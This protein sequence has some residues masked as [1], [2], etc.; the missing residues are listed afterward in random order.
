VS[1][2]G[3]VSARAPVLLRLAH[4]LTGDPPLAA[5][6]VTKVV[7]RRRVRRAL[8]VADD[9]VVVTALVRA[10]LRTGVLGSL[11]A[12]R[13]SALSARDRVATVLAFGVGWDAAGIAEAMRTTGRRVRGAVRR[14]L[15]IAPEQ[16]WRT[17][18]ADVRWDLAAG[19]DLDG[20]AA[21][22]ARDRRRHRLTW[23]IAAGSPLILVAGVA[24]AV[25]RVVTAPP[26]PPP[27]AQVRGLL[28]W[29]ARGGLARDGHFVAAA[30]ALWSRSVHPPRGRIYLLYAGKVGTGRLA[31]LQAVGSDGQPRVAVVGEHDRTVTNPRLRL[32]VVAGLP[33]TDVPLLTVPYDGKP[34]IPG[35]TTAPGARV[36]QALAAPGIDQVEERSSRTPDASIT[37]GASVSSVRPGFRPVLLRGGLTEPWLDS[38]GSLPFTAVRAFAHGE[39]T[40]TGLVDP[41]GVQPRPVGSRLAP[42]SARWAGLPADMQPQTL[43]DDV[44]WWAETCR[45][46]DAT[47]SLVWSG[48]VR[49]VPTVVRLELVRCSGE[50]LTAR[51][52]KG[53]TD[54]A[55][56]I[57]ESVGPAAAYAVV[58]PPDSLA[59]ATLVVVGSTAVRELDIGGV[60]SV[61]RVG[62][63]TTTG[64]GLPS[65]V[66]RS[67]T[68]TSLPVRLGSSA[69]AGQ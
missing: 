31:V 5:E 8:H 68:G 6:L 59:P 30:S 1:P 56:W 26:P 34:D 2:H 28:P 55:Q 39:V 3:T 13:L 69:G 44:L 58:V 15:D 10:A 22:A 49:A 32:D 37:G 38:S 33:R 7:T 63:A 46:G 21:A 42:A 52:V 27:T 43:A 40:F 18:L 25:V 14:A 61:T 51:W 62:R 29:P 64:A 67:A 11:D 16:E 23:S 12:S 17:L 24:T 48:D 4:Q 50:P 36:L 60:R 20:R 53:G 35:R 57:A 65:M 41:H 66:A 54:G 45:G 47:V 9:Q 19:T